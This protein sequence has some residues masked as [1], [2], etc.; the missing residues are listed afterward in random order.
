MEMQTSD[1][2]GAGNCEQIDLFSIPILR[3]YLQNLDIEEI[4]ND[5]RRLVAEAKD[6]HD[7]DT[8]KN[9]TTYFD[10][11]LREKMVD[12]PWYAEFSEQVKDTYIQFI[13]TCY[14][15]EVDHMSRADLH[16]YAWINV[17]NKP[18][19][20]SS[21]NHINSYM[22]GTWY[23]HTELEESQPIQF[24]NPNPAF[25]HSLNLP[26][27]EYG[28]PEYEGVKFTGSPNYHDTIDFFPDNNQFLLWPSALMHEVPPM[29]TSKK[30]Y[31]R[32]SISFNLHHPIG[33]PNQNEAGDNLEYRF[34]G[35]TIM[36]E[37]QDIPQSPETTQNEMQEETD[38][39]ISIVRPLI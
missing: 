4:K 23:V 21:H 30:D 12:L 3:G 5:C 20:H 38:V 31:E 9:Y 2:K 6:I 14:G 28:R 8:S 11:H 35:P 15:Q 7:D 26:V 27:Q 24:R 17:Y 10:N 39:P 32:I 25:A 36:E 34:L 13:R 16:L 1:W 33:V 37:Q 19:S 22:S 18:H 29:V